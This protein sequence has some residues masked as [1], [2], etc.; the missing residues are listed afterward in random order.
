M[1]TEFGGEGI[2]GQRSLA[3]APYTEDYQAE[4]ITRHVSEILK[5]EWVAGF[6]LWLFMDY[7]CASIGIRAINAK[8]LVDEFRRPKLA[9][10]A[11][12]Q[13]LEREGAR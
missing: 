11:L 5:R 12:K 10:N 3:L 2:L 13:L 4:L 9:F 1:V 7:E 8:G 6:F